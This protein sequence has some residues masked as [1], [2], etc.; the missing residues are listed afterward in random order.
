MNEITLTVSQQLRRR[1]VSQIQPQPGQTVGQVAEALEF[2]TSGAVLALINGQ[3]AAWDDVL[4]AGDQLR[5]IPAV[6]GG[7]P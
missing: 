2:T 1:T 6:G 5:L 4:Q 7:S 3:I